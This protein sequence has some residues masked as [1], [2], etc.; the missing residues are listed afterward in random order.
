MN[1]AMQVEFAQAVQHSSKRVTAAHASGFH[2]TLL[3]RCLH[4]VPIVLCAAALAGQHGFSRNSRCMENA[5]T[6]SFRLIAILGKVR[7]I[8]FQ[9]LTPL[10]SCGAEHYSH[11][12]VL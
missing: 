6:W 12:E 1:V 3:E 9:E 4:M 8:P 5:I 10:L 11:E 7:T 2:G